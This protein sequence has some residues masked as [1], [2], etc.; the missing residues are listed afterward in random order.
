MTYRMSWFVNAL[1]PEEIANSSFEFF[2]VGKGTV[3]GHFRC[4]N[5]LP[6]A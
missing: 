5:R 4:G 6:L 1:A 2:D 3:G